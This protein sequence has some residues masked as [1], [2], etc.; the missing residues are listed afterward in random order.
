MAG[1]RT[2]HLSQEEQL[3]FTLMLH[4]QGLFGI[5]E[6]PDEYITLKSKRRSPH[7]LDIR[8]GISNYE[9]RF[10][11]ANNMANLTSKRAQAKGFE[12]IRAAYDYFA[13]TP[14]AMTSYAATIADYSRMGLLQPR[15]DT[16]KTTGNKTPILGRY[17]E[18]QRIAEYDDVVTDGESK[19]ATIRTLGAAGLEIADYFVVVDREEGGAIEV[20]NETGI[21]I[22]PALGVSGM[23]TMLRAE[24]EISSTQF[25]NV[26]EYIGQYGDPHAKAALGLAA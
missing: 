12:S 19:I 6:D 8:P 18:G 20:A 17:V 13:G 21:W 7:Y 1:E 22:T 2:L 15:V 11:I 10:R 25:D 4:E 24:N 16:Q 9:L 14:E 26:V 3:R 5:K 23:A